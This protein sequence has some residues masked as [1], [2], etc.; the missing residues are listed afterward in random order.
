MAPYVVP[1]R[2]QEFFPVDHPAS[3]W[4]LRLMMI[5]DDL[6]FEFRSLRSNPGDGTEEVG[7][8]SY[9]LRRIPTSIFEAH[10]ILEREVGDASAQPSNQVL[11]P[12]LNE[13]IDVVKRAMKIVVPLKNATIA[14]VRPEYADPT[15]FDLNRHFLSNHP[16]WAESITIDPTHFA[17]TSYRAFTSAFLSFA[18]PHA[19]D[20]ESILRSQ[21]DLSEVMETTVPKLLHAIDAL[22]VRHWTLL[23]F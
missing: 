7:R 5:R 21:I 3:P 18:S 16:T 4:L 19:S 17:G 22:L 11:A 8:R 23:G 9:F 15:V 10:G 12:S 1:A 20:N 14:H 6:E 13:V 2:L